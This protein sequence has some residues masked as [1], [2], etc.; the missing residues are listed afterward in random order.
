MYGIFTY[1]YPKKYPN[2]GKYAIHWVF[3]IWDYHDSDLMCVC[4]HGKLG[5]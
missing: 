3:G 2:V 4:I 1:I 5:G